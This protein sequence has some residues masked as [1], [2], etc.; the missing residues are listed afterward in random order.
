MRILTYLHENPDERQS[1]SGVKRLSPHELIDQ[2]PADWRSIS[3][4]HWEE[5]CQLIPKRYYNKTIQALANDMGLV[6]PERNWGSWTV[7]DFFTESAPVRIIGSSH[8]LLAT[9]N[10]IATL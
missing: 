4:Q 2:T 10:A 9:A 8:L 1:T 6:W 7:Y 5:I 3:N